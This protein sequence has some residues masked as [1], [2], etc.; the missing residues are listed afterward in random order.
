MAKKQ[1]KEIEKTEKID[2]HGLTPKQFEQW[3]LSEVSLEMFKR[4]HNIK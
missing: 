2:K 4:E 1:S 3:E